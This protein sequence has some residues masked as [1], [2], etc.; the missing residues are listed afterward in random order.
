MSSDV[1]SYFDTHPTTPYSL[2]FIN[3]DPVSGRAEYY[4][5]CVAKSFSWSAEKGDDDLVK[6]E[7]VL[8]SKSAGEISQTISGDNWKTSGSKTDNY[9]K[10]HLADMSYQVD[11]GGGATDVA[12]NSF[13]MT[14]QYDEVEQLDPNGDGTYDEVGFVGR[15]D[16]TFEYTIPVSYT[17][18]RA[19]E[20]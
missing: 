7:C 2:T 12:L 19:H 15:N 11:V 5:G 8:Q 18:L 1:Y 14:F 3:C 10:F 6:F 4:A 13:S 20:T 16:C 9:G 17:H